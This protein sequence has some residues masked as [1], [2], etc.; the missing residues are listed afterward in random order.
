VAFFLS[1]RWGI[2]VPPF[3][4]KIFMELALALMK[5]NQSAI[6]WYTKI[7]VGKKCI[8]RNRFFRYTYTLKKYMGK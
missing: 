1:D 2:L 8:N 6:K 3:G 7:K 5:E 4:V